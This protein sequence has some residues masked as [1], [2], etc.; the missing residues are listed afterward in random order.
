MLIKSVK[1]QTR[2]KVKKKTLKHSSGNQFGSNSNINK[3][4]QNM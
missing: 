3:S 2:L 4:I 1:N